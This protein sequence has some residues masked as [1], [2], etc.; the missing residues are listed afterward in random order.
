MHIE[1]SMN[2]IHNSIWRIGNVTITSIVE[3]DISGADPELL[4]QGLEPAHVEFLSAQS[5]RNVLV[6]GT[7]FSLP[8]AGNSWRFDTI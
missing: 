3:I 4:F 2:R 1:S 7:H 5:D 6:L 8:T